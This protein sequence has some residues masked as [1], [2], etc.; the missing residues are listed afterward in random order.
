MLSA[1]DPWKP[2]CLSGRAYSRWSSWRGGPGRLG[3]SMTPGGPFERTQR[4]GGER[5]YREDRVV[6]N[7]GLGLPE[8]EPDC[9]FVLV[10]VA[11]V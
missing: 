8:E 6:E 2:D 3:G 9:Q 7:H 5:I 1:G 4:S 10:L 11:P